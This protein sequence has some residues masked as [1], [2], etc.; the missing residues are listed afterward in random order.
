[1]F[2][3]KFLI[4]SAV[5]YGIYHFL[6]RN[7]KTFKFNR[8]YL[9]SIV[10]LA[11]VIPQ[12]IVKTSIVEIP[13]LETSEI[14]YSEIPSNSIEVLPVEE[15]ASYFDWTLVAQIIYAT[16]A[17]ALLIRF[18]MNL[19]S[20]Y[21]LRKAGEEITFKDAQLVKSSKVKSTFSFLNKI[22]VNKSQFKT[23][24]IDDQ[25]LAHENVHIRQR[26]SLDII[27][28]ELVSCLLWFN[29]LVYF[30]KRKIKLNHEFL[31]DAGVLA[32]TQD[33]KAYQLLLLKYTSKQL[34]MNPL[35][36]SHLSYG[37]TKNRFKI[38]FKTTNQTVAALK[39]LTALILITGLVFVM[40]EER[41]IAQSENTP[42][43][44]ET[45]DLPPPPPP[46]KQ[47]QELPPPPPPPVRLSN[48][49]LL[50]HIK[51]RFRDE[52]GEM[53]IEQ[54]GKLTDKQKKSFKD[55]SVESEFFSPPP[56]A[57]YL[58]DEMIKEF[59]DTKTYGVWL[60]GVRIENRVLDN[61]K[62]DDFH[63]Y[64]KGQLKA[65]AVD[66]GKYTYHI[67][68]ITRQA[69]DKNPASK[70]AW[71]KYKRPR[72]IHVPKKNQGNQ[73]LSD[74][75]K[76][77]NSAKQDAVPSDYKWGQGPTKEQAA[78][79]ERKVETFLTVSSNHHI[80]MTLPNG[81]VL[82]K[83][84][85]DY[86]REEWYRW[87][88]PAYKGMIFSPP[89]KEITFEQLEEWKE[90]PDKYTVSI[91]FEPIKNLNE[92]S[93]KRFAF[94]EITEA[95]HNGKTVVELTPKEKYLDSKYFDTAWRSNV[96]YKN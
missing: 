31:A 3:F 76:S 75:K 9:L 17:L 40:G 18:A 93:N 12:L 15:T 84:A 8:F 60:D 56:P 82:V 30:I 55:P 64:F 62:A 46:Q 96:I 69:W 78:K 79:H 87:W 59:K 33:P 11:A 4:S 74:S 42:P 50:S 53:V 83:K 32:Q 29:P 48:G 89:Q 6:L 21:I 67:D 85:K 2:L 77:N 80:K 19:R 54:Y 57:A 91:N 58:T 5:L 22:F 1:M 92:L 27:F 25:I 23:N 41:V 10:I 26:H 36:A 24:G 90:N 13:V 28:I 44:K 43:P 47:T 16:I 52:N 63:H 71:I 95:R 94:S 45:K 38:M 73:S 7:E 88:D 39:Q 61:Y 66:Y 65:N 14:I 35:L 70:G 72:V 68:L 86:T 37:E 20:I 49:E 81:K 51:V 34:H